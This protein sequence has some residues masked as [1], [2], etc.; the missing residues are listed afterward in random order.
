ML[1]PNEVRIAPSIPQAELDALEQQFDD[2]IRRAEESGEWPAKVRTKRDMVSPAAI[3]ATINRYR[4]AN[5]F[6][7]EGGGEGIRATIDHPDRE[8]VREERRV[9]SMVLG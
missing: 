3:R 1:K 8:L 5:W 9:G 2:A 7:V 4:A 6:V